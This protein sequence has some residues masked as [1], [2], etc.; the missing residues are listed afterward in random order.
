MDETI[1]TDYN[2]EGLSSALISLRSTSEDALFTVEPVRDNVFRITFTNNTH[3][4]PPRPSILR[5]QP[6]FTAPP[7]LKRADEQIILETHPN[8]RL[9]IR[10]NPTPVIAVKLDDLQLYSDLSYRSYA[11]DGT[12]ASRYGCFDPETLHLGLGERAA[13]FDL[14]N[15][16]FS[17]SA[18]DAAEYDAYR[19]DPLYKHI[20]FLI[21]AT[22][23]GCVGIVS[24]SH[25]RGTW[26]VGGEIDALWGRYEVM[27]Q[28]WGGLE[29]Y[30]IVAHSLQDL[31]RSYA[32]LVGYPKMVPRWSLGYLASSMGYGESDDPPAQELLEKFPE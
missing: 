23:K 7:G 24:A 13:P 21:R 14:S 25:S 5:P 3:P 20:P 27:R 28:D 1:P 32:D 29:V 11:F 19:T 2:V 6:L 17:L 4:L 26:S 18:L 15:R 16:T 9:T 8:I 31:V 10:I 22:Q 12:G 30:L